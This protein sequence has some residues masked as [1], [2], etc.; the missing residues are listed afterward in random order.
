MMVLIF[1]MVITISANCSAQTK[2]EEYCQ[3]LHCSYNHHSPNDKVQVLLYKE[4]EFVE[5]AHVDVR[6]RVGG[7]TDAGG[8]L[9][10]QQNS[11]ASQHAAWLRYLK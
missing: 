2:W 9:W 6:V 4:G 11:V 8:V 1:V 5:A 3:E 7:G 10:L